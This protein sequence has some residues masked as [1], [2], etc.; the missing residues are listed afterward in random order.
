VLINCVSII[1]DNFD[2]NNEE[3]NRKIVNQISNDIFNMEVSSYVYNQRKNGYG[4]VIDTDTYETITL[5]NELALE[6]MESLENIAKK[7]PD[8]EKQKKA[9]YYKLALSHAEYILQNG[10]LANPKI[11]QNLIM[12]YHNTIKDLDPSHEVPSRAPAPGNRKSG[13]YVATAV[14]GSYDCP[15]VWTLRRYRD[16]KLAK[17]WHGKAFIKIYYAISPTI[18]KWFGNT[19][20]FKNMWRKRLDNMVENLQNEGVESTPYEDEIW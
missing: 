4:S 10:S 12:K 16:Y 6:F 7:F 1:D 13:C 5:F 19:E 11:T 18:V 17:T 15:Q 8:E 9:Y 20:W 3:E 14:Y 2:I